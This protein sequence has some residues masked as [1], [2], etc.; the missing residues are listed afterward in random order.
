MVKK[1][2]KI[3]EGKV[4]KKEWEDIPMTLS[5]EDK[6]DLKDLSTNIVGA[7]EIMAKEIKD[8][9]VKVED[10]ETYVK[11]NVGTQRKMSYCG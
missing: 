11:I 9:K 10:L 3:K 2:I 8:L 1:E 5:Q 4:T 6:K 7:F